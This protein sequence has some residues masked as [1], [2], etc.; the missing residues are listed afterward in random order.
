ML[1]YLSLSSIP[2]LI[3]VAALP[4]VYKAVFPPKV[5]LNFISMWGRKSASSRQES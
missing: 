3:K 1:L 5:S 2:T 4:S